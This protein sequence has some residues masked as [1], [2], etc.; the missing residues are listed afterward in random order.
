VV[1]AFDVVAPIGRGRRQ[2]LEKIPG[3]TMTFALQPLRFDVAGLPE[4]QARNIR[5]H[6]EPGR[7]LA[8]PDLGQ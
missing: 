3:T 5:V 1:G 4:G 7:C 8:L 6:L 2:P